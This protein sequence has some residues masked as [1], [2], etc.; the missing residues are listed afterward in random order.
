[1]QI[2][3]SPLSASGCCRSSLSPPQHS[4]IWLMCST[5]CSGRIKK[6]TEEAMKESWNG[7]DIRVCKQSEA[8]GGDSN[9]KMLLAQKD[10]KLS[11]LHELVKTCLAGNMLTIYTGSIAS[12]VMIEI[13]FIVGQRYLYGFQML[14][15]Y[16]CSEYP[17]PNTIHCY[18]PRSKE[19]SFF[20]LFMACISLLLNLLECCCLGWKMFKQ[21]PKSPTSPTP[22]EPGL[23][24]KA[25]TEDKRFMEDLQLEMDV[26]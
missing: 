9:D 16:G 13:G 17:C 20:M 4:S 18:V 3:P 12:K 1:M 15:S 11:L 6:K 22:L 21:R 19:K 26:A 23:E 25:F 5:L 8:D 14:P 10:E 2:S 24:R 7:R